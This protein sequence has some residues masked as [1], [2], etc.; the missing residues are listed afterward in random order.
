MAD[1]PFSLKTRVCNSTLG[2][3]SALEWIVDQYEI[4]KDGKSGIINDPNSWAD[5][6][7]NPRYIIDLI[8]KVTTVSIETMRLVASMDD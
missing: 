4:K 2:R 6:H 5:E 7:G 1:P 3:R 8:K